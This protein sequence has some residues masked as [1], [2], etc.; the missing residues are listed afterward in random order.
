MS[1]EIHFKS[2]ATERYDTDMNE[3]VRGLLA[4]RHIAVHEEFGGTLIGTDDNDPNASDN[5]WVIDTDELT[6]R[7]VGSDISQL[8]GGRNVDVAE[9]D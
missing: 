5:G 2:S 9:V 1:W 6:A 7:R 4:S 3:K 8:L